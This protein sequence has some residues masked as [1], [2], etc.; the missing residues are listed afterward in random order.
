[1]SDENILN[2]PDKVKEEKEINFTITMKSDGNVTI[3]GPLS[4]KPLCL[5]LLEIGKDLMKAWTP[6]KPKI[7]PARHGII[8]FMRR[9]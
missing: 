6:D 3:N 5:Y 7:T 8:D 4:N 1:M 2:V 9:K